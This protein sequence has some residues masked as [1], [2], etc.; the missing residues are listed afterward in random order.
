MHLP[1]FI[2]HPLF[3]YLYRIERRGSPIP[4][5]RRDIRAMPEDKQTLFDVLLDST[6]NSGINQLIDYQLPYPK[7]DFLNYVCDW[8]GYVAHGSV[9]QDL[10]ML[11]PFRYSQDSSEFGNRHQIF[12]S[13]DGIWAIWFAILDKSKC[14]LTENGCIRL[15]S[16]SKRFKY[17][18]FDLPVAC[19]YDPPFTDGM[20]YITH[21]SEFPNH[22]RD[23]VLNWF[24]AE[25]DEWGS[26][27]PVKPLFRLYVT[28]QDFPY[29]DKVQF[30]L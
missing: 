24:D 18:H 1:L 14:H 7:A 16:G 6:L 8:R 27:N 15:G 21:A 28:P 5:I 20:I 10:S 17:Y 22:R 11:Q 25:I 29:L 30:R 19:R 4:P 12:C 23:L 13:P 26:I 2:A 3:Y 9:V